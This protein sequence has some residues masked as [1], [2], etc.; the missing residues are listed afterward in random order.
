MISTECF[1]QLNVYC[2]NGLIVPDLRPDGGLAVAHNNANASKTGFFSKFFKRK[3]L[4]FKFKQLD[5][6]F[7]I[8]FC[9][10]ALILFFSLL[11]CTCFSTHL[12][13]SN[14]TFTTSLTTSIAIDS[15]CLLCPHCRNGSTSNGT[16]S[17]FHCKGKT[18]QACSSQSVHDL[19]YLDTST[20]NHGPMGSKLIVA[21]PQ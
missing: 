10:Q 16:A 15:S 12:A 2:V 19:R 11:F 5:F 8:V 6:G 20:N 18:S 9:E 3:L 14:S 21:S 4:L 13:R 17:H 1:Q 7:V